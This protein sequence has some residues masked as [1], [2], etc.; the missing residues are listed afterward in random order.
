MDAATFD[1]L[2]R[3]RGRHPTEFGKA[4]QI[5]L[6]I[7]FC[8]LGFGRVVE[9]SVQG[10]DIDISDHPTL[11]NFSIEVK[12]TLNDTLQIG[13]KDIKGLE[14]RAKDGY[15][16]AFAVLRLGLLSDWIIARAKGIPAGGI[17]IGR[18]ET[19]ALPNLQNE[20]NRVF[21]QVVADYARE[22]LRKQ[23]NE[24]QV[25]LQRSLANEKQKAVRKGEGAVPQK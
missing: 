4:C 19:R 25:Y 1:W 2:E 8:H 21:P 12:T 10:V 5:L 9:R 13:H 24:V 16:T 22:I 3:I 6:A 18:L 17:P 7:S 15:E 20:L 11:P 14:M 23:R